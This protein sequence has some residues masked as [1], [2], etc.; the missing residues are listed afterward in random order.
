MQQKISLKLPP[1]EAA[2]EEAIRRSIAAHSNHSSAISGY[3]ISNNRS[4]PGQNDLDQPDLDCFI[5]EPVKERSL[6]AF[7]SG[8]TKAGKKP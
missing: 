8:M 6:P 7:R 1:A 5:G 3:H 2:D 4:M